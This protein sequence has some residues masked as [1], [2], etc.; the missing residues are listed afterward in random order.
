[1]LTGS[2][3]YGHEFERNGAFAEDGVR[4]LAMKFWPTLSALLDDLKVKQAMEIGLT[5]GLLERIGMERPGVGLVGLDRSE[6]SLRRA[7]EGAA[8][9]KVDSVKWLQGDV[10][11]MEGWLKSLNN[12]EPG[13]IFSVHFHEFLAAGESKM[14]EFLRAIKKSLPTWRVLAFEQPRLPHEDRERISE[15]QWLYAQ[16]NVLI[17]HLIGNGRIL[18]Q[19][20][21]MDIGRE[22][23]C[24][25]VDERSCEYLGYR[26]FVFH[27]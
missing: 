21:W 12:G 26:A 2:G 13:L 19:K 16:S 10:F 18:D 20:N 15:S 7:S 1:M 23:G 3:R 22:A 17:H 6:A 11:R 5:T 14:I 9:M 24:S 27:F 4:K 8:K 25:A